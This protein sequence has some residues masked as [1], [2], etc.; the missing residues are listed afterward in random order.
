MKLSS[1]DR[2]QLLIVEDDPMTRALLRRMLQQIGFSSVAEAADGEV[3]FQEIVIRRP[4]LVL[5]DVHMEPVDGFELVRRIR[6]F[7]LASIRDTPIIMLT[8]DAHEATVTTA[9]G[10]QVQGYLTKPVDIDI[11]RDRLE[12]VLSS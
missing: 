8:A 11:L 6:E 3:G 12:A 5:C 4:H 9:R 10:L 1:L 7:R 2:Y